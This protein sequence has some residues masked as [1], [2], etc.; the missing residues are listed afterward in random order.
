MPR[1]HLHRLSTTFLVVLA[2]L[3][4]QLALASYICAVIP[5]ASQANMEMPGG[6]PCEGM[7]AEQP[8]LC[9]QHCSDAPQ[10]VDPLKVPT[11]GVPAVAQVAVIHLVLG[12]TL[13]RAHRARS[14]P[15]TLAP[16]DPLFL[17]T[18]RL[19]V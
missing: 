12:D 8:N 1:R 6:E 14:R 9:F 19:R 4:S 7:D 5:A 17:S 3:F 10:N 2:L 11:A 13:D 15:E 18:L 16:P